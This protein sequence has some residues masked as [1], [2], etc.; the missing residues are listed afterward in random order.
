MNLCLSLLP[1][2]GAR[3]GCAHKLS[4]KKESKINQTVFLLL[5]LYLF[6]VHS[7][8]AFFGLFVSMTPLTLQ[9]VID[10]S[11]VMAIVMCIGHT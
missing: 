8:L 10:Y 7:L 5:K 9:S 3:S 6:Y 1:F 11:W 2:E 4:V